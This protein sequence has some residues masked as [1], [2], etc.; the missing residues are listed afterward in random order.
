[1]ILRPVRPS[2]KFRQVA[3][4]SCTQEPYVRLREGKVQAG[5][6][7]LMHP[8]AVRKAKGGQAL[9]KAE[10][11]DARDAQQALHTLRRA[12]IKR[13]GSKFRV[14]DVLFEVRDC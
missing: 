4:D 5:G 7:R 10:K 9:E 1:V 8:G 6:P 11:P 2:I 14:G 12:L 3:L 13:R